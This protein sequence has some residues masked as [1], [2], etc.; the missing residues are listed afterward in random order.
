MGTRFHL[1]SLSSPSIITSHTALMLQALTH[2]RIIDAARTASTIHQRS[3]SLVDVLGKP[4]S[5]ATDFHAPVVAS[6]RKEVTLHGSIVLHRPNDAIG[7]RL[8]ETPLKRRNTWTIYAP[9]AAIVNPKYRNEP[10]I[11]SIT[12]ELREMKGLMLVD[13]DLDFQ[14]I[15]FLPLLCPCD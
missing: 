3:L 10:E 9:D 2:W 11:V 13:E 12:G 1:L 5:F 4:R 8:W 7:K 14:M 6:E 15:S